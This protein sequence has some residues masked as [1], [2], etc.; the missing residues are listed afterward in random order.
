MPY[1]NDDDDKDA[2]TE[3]DTDT[4]NVEGSPEAMGV[5]EK[6]TR[7]KSKQK[8]DVLE[9]RA[10]RGVQKVKKMLKD[11]NL[12]K[13]FDF[14]TGQQR[15]ELDPK[16]VETLLDMVDANEDGVIKYDEFSDIVMAGAN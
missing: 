7:S 14:Y 11:F 4:N 8:F 5:Q 13:Y 3:T 12:L 10:A 15:G 16:V 6:T 9:A 1:N 2:D